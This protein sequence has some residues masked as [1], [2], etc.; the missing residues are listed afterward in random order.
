LLL[1]VDDGEDGHSPLARLFGVER[2]DRAPR[3]L[4]PRLEGG[5]LEAQRGHELFLRSVL[6]SDV[7]VGAAVRSKALARFLTA[8]PSFHEMGVFNH[9]L[10][11]LKERD[12]SGEPLYDSIVIDMPATGHTLALTGLPEILLRLIPRGPIARLLRE[13]QAILNDPKTASAWVV[14]L[15]ETLP[16]SE[17]LELVAGLAKTAMSVGG[18]IVNRLPDNPFSEGEKTAL[19]AYLERVRVYGSIAFARLEESRRALSRLEEAIELPLVLLRD[20]VDGGSS[21]VDTLT[22]ELG[23]A[24]VAP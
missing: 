7:L 17:S 12:W 21:P 6:P 20:V 8:A 11:L 13:G 23:A 1:D 22:E 3:A 5:R 19:G 24:V 15:P 16:V 9:L 18:V 2:F 14:T 4:G 10:H